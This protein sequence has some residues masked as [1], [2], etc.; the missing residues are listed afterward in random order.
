MKKLIIG[1]GLIAISLVFTNFASAASI[2]NVND[3]SHATSLAKWFISN[4][5]NNNNNAVIHNLATSASNSGG[6]IISSLMT[7]KIPR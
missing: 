3:E 5:I 4:M 1:L 6:N 2:S 7:R